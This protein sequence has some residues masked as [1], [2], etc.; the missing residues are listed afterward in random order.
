MTITNAD[1]ARQALELDVTEAAKQMLGA[2]SLSAVAPE[3]YVGRLRSRDRLVR[4]AQE[5]SDRARDEAAPIARAAR[6]DVDALRRKELEAD[7]FATACLGSA[8]R[9]IR[10]LPGPLGAADLQVVIADLI[11]K[12]LEKACQD[13]DLDSARKI[14]TRKGV[15]QRRRRLKAEL[16][17][18]TGQVQPR[19]AAHIAGHVRDEL[20]GELGRRHE[21][22][23]LTSDALRRR[24]AEAEDP[25]EEIPGSH[26]FSCGPRTEVVL[27]ATAV[28][29]PDVLD[30][31]GCPTAAIWPAFGAVVAR[32]DLAVMESPQDAISALSWF[33]ES[34]VA[35]AL[36]GVTLDGLYS[37]SGE[38]PEVPNWLAKAAPRLQ[39]GPRARQHDLVRLAQVPAATSGSLHQH[40]GHHIQTA[41]PSAE[42]NRLQ[43]VELT[44]AYT[45]D[46]VLEADPRGLAN[47]LADV[48]PRASNPRLAAALKQQQAKLTRTD[49]DQRRVADRE[50]EEDRPHPFR[51]GDPSE[52]A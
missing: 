13:V 23:V 51:A 15:E 33:L 29:R 45:A 16:D 52:A 49:P 44:Y 1:N 47:V 35:G 34:I 17:T 46:E 31:N 32:G 39:V 22:A 50:A 26:R 14:K 28:N 5:I 42:P 7:P 19:L 36:A 8:A 20:A 40:V 37:L 3:T 24:C 2:L 4:L 30:R 38:Q 41:A 6:A 21:A 11:S 27:R 48:I 9:G 18:F 10:E 43:L 12:E 25:G